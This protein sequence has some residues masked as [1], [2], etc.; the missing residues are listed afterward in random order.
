[1]VIMPLLG[2]YVKFQEYKN[3]ALISN[4]VNYPLV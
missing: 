3:F 4:I 2:F 1:M